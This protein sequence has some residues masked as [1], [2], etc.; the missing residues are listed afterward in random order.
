MRVIKNVESF[1]GEFS[2]CA[3]SGGQDLL[4]SPE[5]LNEDPYAAWIIKVENVTEEDDLMDAA[6][7]EAFCKEN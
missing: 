3:F 6:E 1:E 2:V 5:L 4:D 7:Y